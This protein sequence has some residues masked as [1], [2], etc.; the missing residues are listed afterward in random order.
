ME[1]I[2]NGFLRI[3][4]LAVLGLVFVFPASPLPAEEE[5]PTGQFS[6]T[7]AN[8]YVWRGYELSRNSVVI[9]P[10]INVAYKGFS[11]GLWGNL[12]TKPYCDGSKRGMSC[13]ADWNET[14]LTLSYAKNAGLFNIG[15][16]YIYYGLGPLNN[17]AADRPDGQDVFVTAS[18]NTI[19]SPALTVYKDVDYYR[20]WYFLIGL[21][22]SIEVSNKLSI[23][24]SATASYLL[25]TD[26]ATYPNYDENALTTDNKFR[27]FHD[28]TFTVS[29]PFKALPMLTLTPMISYVFPLSSAAKYEMK[30]LGLKGS[31]LP[32]DRKSNFLVASLTA[33]F[34]F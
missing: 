29:A 2:L 13:S 20:N 25:S 19:L 23:I 28:G 24:F 12:D 9:Q 31:D 16:G 34:A 7:A 22:H 15:F 30:G 10:F 5:K 4:F 6:L 11:A 18:F 1:E 8:A 14:D 3:I 32:A 17:D 21:S 26:E 33:A 27:N